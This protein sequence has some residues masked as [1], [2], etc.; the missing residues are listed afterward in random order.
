[1]KGRYSG[2]IKLKDTSVSHLSA[3]VNGSGDI[4]LTG[5]TTATILESAVRGSGDIDIYLIV[6]I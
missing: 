4:E 3:S 6:C 2:D 1:M 5:N